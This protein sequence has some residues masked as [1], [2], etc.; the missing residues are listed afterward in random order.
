LISFTIRICVPGHGQKGTKQTHL[1]AHSCEAQG[2]KILRDK[3]RKLTKHFSV[4]RL[5]VHHSEFAD[6]E[7][8]SIVVRDKKS[9]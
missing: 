2:E 9:L 4:S 1:L 8:F 7:F 3:E 5:T 6:K